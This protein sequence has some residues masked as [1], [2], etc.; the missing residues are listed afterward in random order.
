MGDAVQTI[1]IEQGMPTV[2]QARKRLIRAI[3]S[4]NASGV[5]ILKVIHGYGSS[6]KGGK[7]LIAIRR[8]ITKRRSEGKVDRVIYGENWSIFDQATQKLTHEYPELHGDCDL[9]RYNRGITMI[10]LSYRKPP[11]KQVICR[12]Q[13]NTP[14]SERA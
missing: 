7:L 13:K 6:G 10:E 5:R 3:D 12:E 1:N 9:D 2:D 4:A 11:K 14:I 8:S